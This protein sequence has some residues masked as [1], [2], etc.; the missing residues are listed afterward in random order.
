MVRSVRLA[1]HASAEHCSRAAELQAVSSTP[2]VFP[3]APGSILSDASKRYTERE[4]SL[5]LSKAAELAG[6]SNSVSRIEDGLTLKETTSI[7]AEA[8]LDA[9][10]IARAARLIPDESRRSVLSQAMGGVLRDR[11]AFDLPGALPD[12]MRDGPSIQRA[13]CSRLMVG[14]VSRSFRTRLRGVL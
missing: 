8:G 12:E 5:I 6:S 10:S 9:D 3:S 2:N 4:F 1:A 14:R 13:R 7:G 11:R